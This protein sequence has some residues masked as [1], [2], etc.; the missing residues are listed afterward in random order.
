MN[1]AFPLFWIISLESSP[2]YVTFKEHESRSNPTKTIHQRLLCIDQNMS[3]ERQ[4]SMYKLWSYKF[5]LI[6]LATG[7]ISNKQL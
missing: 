4:N 2:D 3:T 1:I 5:E 7:L 6:S